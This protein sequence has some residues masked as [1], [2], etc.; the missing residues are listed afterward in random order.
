VNGAVINK[1]VKAYDHGWDDVR[2]AVMHRELPKMY[3]GGGGVSLIN[4]ADRRN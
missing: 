3:S 4:L 2:Y 1:P